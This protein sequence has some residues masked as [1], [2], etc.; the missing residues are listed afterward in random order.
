MASCA[1]GAGGNRVVDEYKPRAHFL[2]Y[3]E[4]RYLFLEDLPRYGKSSK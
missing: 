3:E 4:L 1:Q 2:H